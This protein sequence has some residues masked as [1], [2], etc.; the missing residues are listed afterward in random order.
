MDVPAH[1]ERD[2][3][4]SNIVITSTLRAALIALALLAGSAPALAMCNSS[5]PPDFNDITAIEFERNGCG[6]IHPSDLDTNPTLDC[7]HYWILFKKES[8]DAVYSQ[9]SDR[10][11]RGTYSVNI[12]LPEVVDLLRR[13]DF[14]NLNPA[15]D[16]T[17]D[18][19]DTVLTV[20]RCGVVT[21]LM[22]F[23]NGQDAV[24]NELFTGIDG[25]LVNAKLT[26][27][28]S[29]P[30]TFGDGYLFGDVQH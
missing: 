25:L 6:D 8:P 22:M 10:P 19:T 18:I 13:L 27:T 4:P 17:T 15:D 3:R 1:I 14:F 5:S 2:R 28:S 26:K 11:D 7:S 9:S 21:R 12:T 23:P 20:R 24:T 30:Q 29:D 16:F